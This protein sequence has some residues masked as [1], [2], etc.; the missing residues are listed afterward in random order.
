MSSLSPR[1]QRA[2]P[3]LSPRA[4]RAVPG[5]LASAHLVV[6]PHFPSITLPPLLNHQCSTRQLEEG[7]VLQTECRRL[8]EV[9]GK[10]S[11]HLGVVVEGL[12]EEKAVMINN[13]LQEAATVDPLDPTVLTGRPAL[14]GSTPHLPSGMLKN[15]LTQRLRATLPG[16]ES[17]YNSTTSCCQD[18]T[19]HLNGLMRK[20]NSGAEQS[21]WTVTCLKSLN[22]WQCLWC[23]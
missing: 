14:S 9:G 10:T 8:G 11:R 17:L 20:V 2:V 19:V 16:W 7:E 22:L 4:Q 23:G 13:K 18:S 15:P 3:G 6:A 1:A 12:G 5:L 21:R